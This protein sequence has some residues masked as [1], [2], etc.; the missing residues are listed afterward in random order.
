MWSKR[1][2]I[3]AVMLCVT[4]AVSA[5]GADA[6]S[7]E[8]ADS[9][10]VYAAASLKGVLDAAQVSFSEQYPEIDLAFNFAGTHVLKTQLEQ[11]ADAD[12]FLAARE[13]DVQD[14]QDQNIVERY[15]RLADNRLVVVMSEDSRDR[16]QSIRDLADE[17]VLLV[18]AESNAPV[19][20][21]ALRM[22]D[23][24]EQMEPFGVDFKERLMNNIVS[25]ESNEQHVLAKIELGE[26]DAGVIYTSSLATAAL[27]GKQLAS[28]PIPEQANVTSS[29]Y[30]ASL[31]GAS[32]ETAIFLDWLQSE[33]GKAL[34]ESYGYLQEG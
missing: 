8:D 3:L 32:P 10:T 27:A 28:L 14:L 20:E 12:L 24:L 9:V 22:I 18:L 16:L 13:Q 23:R 25:Y 5:C 29:Y 21:Y 19:G 7:Q 2:S 17:N 26:A 1:I 30:A 15:L 6:S 34:L 33:D 11:G 4:V 31:I